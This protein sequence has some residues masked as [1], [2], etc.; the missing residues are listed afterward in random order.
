[1][2]FD[3]HLDSATILSSFFEAQDYQVTRANAGENSFID[4]FDDFK[5]ASPD[6]V[7]ISVSR[8]GKQTEAY[9]LVNRIK[10]CD[11]MIK[12]II[13]L[14]DELLL[15]DYIECQT[16]RLFIKPPVLNILLEHVQ[17]LL[18]LQKVERQRRRVEAIAQEQELLAALGKAVAGVAHEVNNMLCQPIALLGIVNHQLIDLK[19]SWQKMIGSAAALPEDFEQIEAQLQTV[20]ENLTGLIVF[21]RKVLGFVRHNADIDVFS[22]NKAVE[23]A[24]FHARIGQSRACQF[25]RSSLCETEAL[26]HGDRQKIMH[27]VYNI[28]KNAQEAMP[29]NGTITITSEFGAEDNF[30]IRISDDGPGI[31]EAILPQIF[32]DFFTTKPEGEGTGLGL[33]MAKT[34]IEEMGGHINV[35]TQ[36][37]RGTTFEILLPILQ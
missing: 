19:N 24:I 5:V 36:P 8:P 12:V 26:L 15:T 17:N 28:I 3:D 33:P 18:E 32:D 20:S 29:K 37:D 13:M 31:P 2:V 25:I 23:E 34:A 10:G 16:E 35:F 27:A 21:M 6:I 30:I 4:C 11:P 14:K 1:M 22:P 9:A 7:L